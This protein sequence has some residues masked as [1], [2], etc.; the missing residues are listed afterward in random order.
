M[1]AACTAVLSMILLACASDVQRQPSVLTRHG[2]E[3]S[4]PRLYSSTPI[5]LR[6]ATGYERTIPPNTEFVEVGRIREGRVLRP[7][8]YV[9]TVEGAHVHEA[10]LVVDGEHIVGFYLP[11]ERAFSP[12]EKIK[13]V[14]REKGR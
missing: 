12:N 8:S 13:A 14:F 5:Q 2:D 6:L 9:L 1:R 4:R 11:V 3:A 10:Y 7:L